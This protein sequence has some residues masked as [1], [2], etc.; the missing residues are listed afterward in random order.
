MNQNLDIATA[1]S[2]DQLTWVQDI[3]SWE[4]LAKRLSTTH[5]TAE[6][7]VTYISSPKPRQ[8]EIKDVGGFVG[9]Y[10]IDGKRNKQS[11]KHRQILALDVDFAYPDFWLDFAMYFKCAAVVYSTHKYSI[12][13][14]RLRLVI[15]VDRPVSP[16]EYEAIVRKIAGIMGTKHFD[17]TTFTAERLMYWPSTSKDGDYYFKEQ[18]GEWLSADSILSEYRDWRNVAEWPLCP[19]ESEVRKTSL[20]KQEDP[21]T[22]DGVI[23]AFCRVYSIS[24]A[25]ETFIPG[26]YSEAGG[27]RYT[28]NG[29]TTAAGAVCYED[30]FLYSHHSTDPISGMTCNAFD[31]IRMHKF[32]G[33]FGQMNNMARTDVKVIHELGIFKTKPETGTDTDW[34]EQMQ[35]DKKGNYQTTIDNFLLI[36]RNDSKIKGKFSY[37]EFDNLIYR[38]GKPIADSDEATLRNYCEKTYELYHAA[39]AKDAFEISCKDN[40]FHPVRDYLHSLV[41]DGTPRLDTVF[42]DQLGV[43]DTEYT[44]AV[45][46]KS[47]TAAVARVMLPGIKFDYMTVTI[48]EQGKGKSSLLYDLGKQWFSDTL[49]SVVGKDAY[50][51]IQGA[52]L[53]EIAELSAVKKAEV[54]AV[55]KFLT[56][57]KDRF[58]PPF[59]KHNIEVLRQTVFFGSTNEHTFLIDK[60]GNRR[61]WPLVVTKKYE[62]GSINPDQIWAEAVW[63]YEQGEKLYLTPELES[64]AAQ[65]QSDHTEADERSGVIEEF[66]NMLLPANWTEMSSYERVS[67]F[68]G[69]DKDRGV[70]TRHKVCAAEIWVEAFKNSYSD[71][72]PFNTKF[73]H[74]IM[75]NMEGWSRGGHLS[76][77]K[78]GNQ[79]SYVRSDVGEA[80]EDILFKQ[81][82]SI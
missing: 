43:A 25:I 38:D 12:V 53:V 63:R 81:E 60:T 69:P 27:D 59:G 52:W 56:K 21:L 11:I 22:K 39:K 80:V 34:L 68:N 49:D 78:Y 20:K 23:G 55:K 74:T 64:M 26:V 19:T 76:Y 18:K 73:I 66:I 67:Y 82:E 32:N 58:R 79:R 50:I 35:V 51:Q 62:P 36:L 8:D 17:H 70:D 5:R 6:S 30:K 54:E 37:N 24:E 47:L 42:I 72:T 29:G 28:F 3:W 40:G 44:R 31:L 15:P 46:R 57:Q 13:Q 45:T 71:M 2:R 16:E 1:N 65:Q 14:P 75:A 61:F 9:G 4:K 7:Y 10:L 41:W 77:K 48:G 33:D